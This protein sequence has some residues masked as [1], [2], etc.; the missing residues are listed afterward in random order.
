MGTCCSCHTGG[1]FVSNYLEDERRIGEHEDG[2]GIVLRG[3]AGARIRLQGSSK[4][5]SMFSM[6]G[7][8][9]INQ[10]AMTVW[11]S[12][13]GDKDMFLCGVFD[14][15]GP[16]GHKVARYI[17]D[18][19]PTKIS[20][21]YRQP[22]VECKVTEIRE[23]RENPE[24]KNPLFLSWKARLT[25]CFHE[26]DEQLE[27]EASIESYCSG[28]TS[29]C[30]LR[31]IWDVLS[32]DEVV[33]IVGSSRRR[34]VTAKMLVEQARWAWRYKFPRSKI[35]DCAAVCL[36]FKSQRPFLSKSVS[37]KTHLS[38]NYAELDVRSYAGSMQSNDALDTVLNCKVDEE[39]PARDENGPPDEKGSS[40][41]VRPRRKR[42]ERE[43]KDVEE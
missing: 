1:R 20:K 24:S 18:L 2:D 11:E 42:H 9:G 21:V 7:K 41:L 37:E 10:D 5:A 15:H 35:D 22:C 34:A 16:S 8:K 13:S 25:K 14:G 17:R 43:L 31:K 29:V 12:F 36:F 4:Y 39:S 3:D 27:G 19:L 28:T 30:V 6:Q 38:L 32:N 33:Q 26:M 23:C 40:G